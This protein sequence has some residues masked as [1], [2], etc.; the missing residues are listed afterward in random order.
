MIYIPEIADD[1]QKLLPLLNTQNL[2][3]R[4]WNDA[5]ERVRKLINKKYWGGGEEFI[6]EL[7]HGELRS[8]LDEVN[9]RREVEEAFLQDV[10]GYIPELSNLSIWEEPS[11]LQAITKAAKGIEV[12]SIRHTKYFE[13]RKSGG[14]FGL[15]ISRPKIR[16]ER[17]LDFFS[18]IKK[19]KLEFQE[20]YR[21]G[22]LCQ[23]KLKRDKWRSLTKPQQRLFSDKVDYLALLL[24]EYADTKDKCFR[25]LDPFYWQ[26]CRGMKIEDILGF[27]RNNY[28][29]SK[30]SSGEVIKGLF[31]GVIG[32]DDAEVIENII[33]PKNKDFLVIEL[34]WPHNNGLPEDPPFPPIEVVLSSDNWITTNVQGSVN[35]QIG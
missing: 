19:V 12:T 22:I 3:A 24:Y 4:C 23:A 30:I 11:G 9:K 33:S 15:L 29:P 26:P 14:D 35:I 2:I 8:V 13:G 10:L 7:F 18:E 25:D 5:E 32:T 16:I 28:F 17:E 34:G 6:T 27:L 21:N 1:A 31:E 20:N